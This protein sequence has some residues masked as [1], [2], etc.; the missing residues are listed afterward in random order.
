MIRASLWFLLITG[1]AFLPAGCGEDE[2]E[3]EPAKV[4]EP[5]IQSMREC[6][7]RDGHLTRALDTYKFSIGSYPTTKQG[8]AALNT[9]PSGLKDPADWR[10]PYLA[11]E[12]EDC[13]KD[14]WDREWVYVNPGKTHEGQYDLWSMGEDG[15][16]DKGA[17]DDTLN[18]NVR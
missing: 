4:Y 3:G 10:G 15:K 11:A 17:G 13:L 7:H 16:D 12:H 2:D 14:F 6:I 5:H 1:F 9:R 18:W 8:L